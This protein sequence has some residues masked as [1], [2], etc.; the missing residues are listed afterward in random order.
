MTQGF[1]RGLFGLALLYSAV[2]GATLL[3]TVV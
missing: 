3:S 1:I 2:A